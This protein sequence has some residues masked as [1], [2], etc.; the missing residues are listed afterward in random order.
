MTNRNNRFLTGLVLRHSAAAMKQ[1][2][3]CTV[4]VRKLKFVL[5][6]TGSD[7]YSKCWTLQKGSLQWQKNFFWSGLFI[8]FLQQLNWKDFRTRLLL[9]RDLVR[10]NNKQ[11]TSSQSQEELFFFFVG[12]LNLSRSDTRP[13]T[14]SGHNLAM[15]YCAECLHCSLFHGC[16]CLTQYWTNFKNRC[17][18]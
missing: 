18:L 8:V 14:F 9:K 1:A 15:R 7:C 12:H 10:H 5:S 11:T 16:C 4:N 17:S 6:L 13:S 3:M 2:A